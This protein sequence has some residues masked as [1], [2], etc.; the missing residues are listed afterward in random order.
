[1]SSGRKIRFQL[2]RLHY[3]TIVFS[4]RASAMRDIGLALIVGGVA[5][6]LSGLIFLIPTE[7]RSRASAKSFE[8]SQAE[9]EYYLR[10]MRKER[11]ETSTETGKITRR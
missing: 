1:M 5:L 7:R 6:A 9:I 3:Q 2:A 10:E 11:G 8:D 4:F